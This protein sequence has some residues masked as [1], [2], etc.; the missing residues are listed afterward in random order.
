MSRPRK[1]KRLVPRLE[2]ANILCPNWWTVSLVR[3][4]DGTATLLY[5][6][7]FEA[8]D[9]EVVARTVEHLR[10]VLESMNGKLTI[11]DDGVSISASFDRIDLKVAAGL[12]AGE[13][14]PW[15]NLANITLSRMLMLA[16]RANAMESRARLLNESIDATLEK[17]REILDAIP[18]GDFAAV[19]E[20]LKVEG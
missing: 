4:Q 5:G 19:A 16:S 13:F 8:G 20:S 7:G 14:L 3:N 10:P 6:E 1:K 11:S 9:E 12:I 18:P 17:T 2:V 15:S